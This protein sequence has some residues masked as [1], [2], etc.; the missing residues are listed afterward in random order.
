MANSGKNRNTSQFFFF[1][2]P[3]PQYL[4]KK[5][6]VFGRVLDGFHIIDKLNEYGSIDGTPSQHIVISN[7]GQFKKSAARYYFDILEKR[8][9]N[10]FVNSSREL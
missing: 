4:D 2:G 7:C 9:L 10:E 1:T 8:K 5:H 6:V 3:N